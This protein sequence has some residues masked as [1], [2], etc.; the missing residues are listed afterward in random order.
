MKVLDEPL[1]LTI[2]GG[3]D[4]L[5]MARVEHLR[6]G[7]LASRCDLLQVGDIISSVNGINTSRLKHDDIINLLK[8]VGNVLNLGIDYE[9]PPT[10]PPSPNQVQK[11]VAVNLPRDE[12]PGS[13]RGIVLRGGVNNEDPMKTR[14][15]VVSFIRPGS[16][17][18]PNTPV[19]VGDRLVAAGNNRL[20]SC[21]LD[22]ALAIIDR[23]EVFTFQYSAQIV[24]Q[25]QNAKGPLSIEVAKPP[26]SN[27]GVNLS[28]TVINHRHVICISEIVAASIADRCGALHVGDQVIRIDG[29]HVEQLT[30]DDATRLLSSPS[31]QIKLEILPVSH[32]RLSIEG[33]KSIGYPGR[34]TPSIGPGSTYGLNTGTFSRSGTM[35][36]SKSNTF[37]RMRGRKL[38]SGMSQ[39]SVASFDPYA[40]PNQG[41]VQI[42][43]LLITKKCSRVTRVEI[44]GT[45]NCLLDHT[46]FINCENDLIKFAS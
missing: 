15:L 11:I 10:F 21:T 23:E 30:L 3:L 22:E 1:G 40:Q 14:P 12:V 24:D 46:R 4:K 27:L 9:L 18:D 29:H 17:C 16:L 38:K 6:A 45:G 8:N 31:D 44:A 28:V 2:A 25:V 26:G 13:G 36:S 19:K 41:S 33:P 39:M 5:S 32:V 7:G 35:M 37:S 42:T 34:Y 43:I 20:D